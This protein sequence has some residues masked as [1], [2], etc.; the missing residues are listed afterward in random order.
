MTSDLAGNADRQ[1]EKRL[2]FCGRQKDQ[3]A[4]NRAEKRNL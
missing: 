4:A 3:T 2:R 1:N